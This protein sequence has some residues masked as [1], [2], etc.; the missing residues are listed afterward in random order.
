MQYQCM[1]WGRIGVHLGMFGYTKVV[2]KSS[3]VIGYM[4]PLDLLFDQA[5]NWWGE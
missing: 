4:V 3:L 2:L 1:G 5:E